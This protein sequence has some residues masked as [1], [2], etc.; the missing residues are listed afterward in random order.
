MKHEDHDHE[1]PSSESSTVLLLGAML[2]PR[3]CLAVQNL[4]RIF[5]LEN[6]K[7]PRETIRL[8]TSNCY[9]RIVSDLQALTKLGDD[10]KALNL[11]FDHV[12]S[13]RIV[14]MILLRLTQRKCELR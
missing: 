5:Q 10:Y 13:V 3:F 2:T 1:K 12:Q 11:D 9:H 14:K 8:G 7:S 4:E 6:R